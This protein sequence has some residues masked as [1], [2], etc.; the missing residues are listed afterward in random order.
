MNLLANPWH[1][2]TV[3]EKDHTQWKPILCSSPNNRSKQKTT[4]EQIKTNIYTST[5]LNQNQTVG[6]TKHSNLQIQSHQ[7]KILLTFAKHILI[8]LQIPLILRK[9]SIPMPPR[10]SSHL[11]S[12]THPD[13]LLRFLKAPKPSCFLL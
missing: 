11:S 13:N 9:N 2:E 4:W 10:P 6:S 5:I 12:Q 1:S 7:S 3:Q 8:E